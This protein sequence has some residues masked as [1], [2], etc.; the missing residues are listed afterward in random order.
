MNTDSNDPTPVKDLH[1]LV[2]RYVGLWNEP[3]ADVRRQLIREL[4]APDGAQVLVDPPQ[5][6]RDAADRLKFAVPPLEVHGYDALEARVTRAYE[7]FVA[8][9]EYAFRPDGDPSQPLS[10]VISFNWT[11]DSRADGE[12][13]GAGLK[14]LAIG[15]D[16]RI[17]I[18]YQ[19]IAP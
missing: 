4:W 12:P 3:D 14:V 8:P 7:M 6:I 11:M 9:G 2:D 13:A 1:E 16:G 5:E 17:R 18:D 10:N 19:F 15:T